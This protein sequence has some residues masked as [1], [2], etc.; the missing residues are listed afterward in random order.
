MVGLKLGL[1][2]SGSPENV[3]EMHILGSYPKP[4][5]SETL[6]MEPSNLCSASSLD[7][8]GAC[9]NLTG[10]DLEKFIPGGK[11]KLLAE[12]RGRPRKGFVF[13][14]GK[15]FKHVC[16]QGR[17]ESLF[18]KKELDIKEKKS[19]GA[20]SWENQKADGDYFEV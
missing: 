4:T 16:M 11:K 1:Q 12:G 7:D 17:K 20:K 13:Q 15:Y 18:K 8:S 10:T 14:N 19:D 3:L 9:Q 5:E 2:P 6:G